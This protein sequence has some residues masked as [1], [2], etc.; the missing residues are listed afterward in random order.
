[1]MAKGGKCQIK[2]LTAHI[3]LCVHYISIP[4]PERCD[5]SV[6]KSDRY[7]AGW[8]MRPLDEVPSCICCEQAQRDVIYTIRIFLLVQTVVLSGRISW[9][10]HLDLQDPMGRLCVDSAQIGSSRSADE[11]HS[12]CAGCHLIKA[13]D[14][15]QQCKGAS[16]I[17]SRRLSWWGLS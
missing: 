15:Q 2:S 5:R 11:A 12:Y 6:R 9:S 17:C 8:Q 4:H 14:P 1:M 3:P 10:C 16:T 7:P 13:T